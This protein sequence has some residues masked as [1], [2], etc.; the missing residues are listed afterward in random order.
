[1]TYTVGATVPVA[2]VFV[3]AGGTLVD[4]TTPPA[5][6]IQD[7]AGAQ[8][9]PTPVH[10][11]TGKYHYDLTV[12]LSG[13][14]FYRYTGTGNGITQTVQEGSVTVAASIFSNSSAIDLCTLDYVKQLLGIKPDQSS[15]DIKLSRMITG[16]SQLFL[17]LVQ[18]DGFKGPVTYAERRNGN[19]S[20]IMVAY[21]RPIV[22]VTSVLINGKTVPQS[23]DGMQPGWVNDTNK[24][25]LVRADGSF[26]SVLSDWTFWKGANNVTLNYSAGYAVTPSDIVD[27]VAIAVAYRNKRMAKLGLS[28]EALT[29]IGTVSYSKEDVPPEFMTVV[30]QYKDRAIIE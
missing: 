27:A 28:S 29:G 20:R 19:G 5:L 8:T 26:P 23:P 22:A 18:T 9:T 10:D 30:K 16:A 17:N 15:D 11:G 2:V 13:L 1:M 14:Y 21:H 7:P 25:Q 3:N 24:I 12:T 6:V 4:P